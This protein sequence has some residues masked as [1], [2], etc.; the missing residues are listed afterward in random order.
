MIEHI[1]K[2]IKFMLSWQ[3]DVFCQEIQEKQASLV[4]NEV[5]IDGLNGEYAI[6]GSTHDVAT[7]AVVNNVLTFVDGVA[8]VNGFLGDVP[9]VVD[10]S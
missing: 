3:T 7:S 6:T 5:S 4:S 1:A 8:K 2:R 9:Q 10:V